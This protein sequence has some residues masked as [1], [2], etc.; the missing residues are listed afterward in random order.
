M[1]EELYCRYMTKQQQMPKN[2]ELSA[3]L[4]EV[5]SKLDDGNARLGNRSGWRKDSITMWWI[6]AHTN[7]LWSFK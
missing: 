1:N 2:V 3:L 4:C 7:Y 5:E 6:S